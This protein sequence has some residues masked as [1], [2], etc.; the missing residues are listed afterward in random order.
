[1]LVSM[2]DALLDQV[3]AGRKLNREQF[4]KIQATEY[5]R[6]LGRRNRRSWLTWSWP[7]GTQRGKTW[8]N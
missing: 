1:M 3:G 5:S 4:R 6:R 8:P 7:F 2:N